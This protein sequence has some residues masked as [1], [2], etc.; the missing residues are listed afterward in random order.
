MTKCWRCKS[1][2]EYIYTLDNVD[3]YYCPSCNLEIKT[4]HETVDA[5]QRLSETYGE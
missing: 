5:V 1:P 3:E 2:L 4:R